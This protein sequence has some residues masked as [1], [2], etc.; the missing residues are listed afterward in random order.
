MCQRQIPLCN[1]RFLKI[2]FW[3]WKTTSLHVLN[4][5]PE[6]LNPLAMTHRLKPPRSC[7][8]SWAAPTKPLLLLLL[9]LSLSLRWQRCDKH[10]ASVGGQKLR[11]SA[12]PQGVKVYSRRD[13]RWRQ[14][15]FMVRS[16]ALLNTWAITV[17]AQWRL[18][19]KPIK[20]TTRGVQGSTVHE[21]MPHRLVILYPHVWIP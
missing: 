16:K 14:V 15:K 6:E 20:S 21:Q 18:H 5:A 10:W 13:K 1:E 2:H 8:R 7:C 3:S 12:G 17:I 9:S 11:H 19:A 4:L